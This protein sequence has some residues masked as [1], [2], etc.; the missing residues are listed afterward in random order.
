MPS[1]LFICTGNIFRSLIAEYAFKTQV[2]FESGHLVGSAGIEAI[3]QPIHPLIHRRLLQKGAD[4]SRHVQRQLTLELLDS[5]DLPVAMSVNHQAFV[6]RR[7][8]RE[9][10]LFNEM[11]FGRNEP[12]LDIHEAVPD[13]DENLQAAHDYALFTIDYIWDAMPQLMSRISRA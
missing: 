13:W 3:P 6:Q 12:L 11:C 5:A 9:I 10:V 7:F 8:G 1:V 4:P 2:G